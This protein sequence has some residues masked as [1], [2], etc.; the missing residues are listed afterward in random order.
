ML[1]TAVSAESWSSL[2]HASSYSRSAI[3]SRWEEVGVGTEFV[4]DWEEF[5]KSGKAGGVVVVIK[6]EVLAAVLSV[7]PVL[8]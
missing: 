1:L 3:R 4:V 7:R 2:F 5:P 8:A 6:R